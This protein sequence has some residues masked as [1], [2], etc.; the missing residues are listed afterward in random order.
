MKF[1]RWFGLLLTV[2]L[3]TTATNAQ[4][5]YGIKAGPNL[6]DVRFYLK[7][8]WHDQHRYW[9]TTLGLHAGF[10]LSVQLTERFSV[11]PEPEFIQKG[12]LVKA[13][14]PDDQPKSRI[15]FSYIQ[16]PVLFSFKVID[17]L[18]LEAG[19]A[20]GHRLSKSSSS[21]HFQFDY[22][23]TLF[24]EKFELSVLGGVRFAVTE[25]V[26]LALRHNYGLSN[27]IHPGPVY[28]QNPDTGRLEGFEQRGKNIVLLFSV[29]Y[30]LTKR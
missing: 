12:F 14:P 21:D 25:N 6:N 23:M 16:L 13:F 9:Q 22:Y 17:K 24:E 8:S 27:I 29:D 19:P 2:T 7:D 1:M 11:R 18:Y 10:F 20:V 30:N 5:S 26:G 3:S 28:V 4:V 15:T